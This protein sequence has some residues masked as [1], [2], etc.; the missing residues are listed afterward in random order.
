MRRRGEVGFLEIPRQS[1]ASAEIENAIRTQA[2]KVAG[3][4]T[5][6]LDA[7]E[8]NQIRQGLVNDWLLGWKFVVKQVWALQRQYGD[9][10]TWFRVV[11]NQEGAQLITDNTAEVYDFEINWD[12]QNAD[13]EVMLLKLEK[14]GQVMAQY[15]RNGQA[16]FGEYMKSFIEAIDPNLAAR[17]VVSQETATQREVEETSEDIAKIYSGQVVNAPQNA[18][19]QL[20][21]QVVE[22]WVKGT[23]EIPNLEIQQRM[24][25]DEGFR[26]RVETYIGQLQHQQQQAQNAL[27]GKL[28]TPAGNV[29]AS[30]Y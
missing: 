24:E 2:L 4:P 10:E 15:D 7:V 23:E 1:T 17:L 6:E 19:A 8:A 14:I 26:A 5:S 22:N 3:R 25:N 28:G 16:N 29:P 18:N 21:M 12:V 9:P 20:R 30:N 13:K 11:N 27:T